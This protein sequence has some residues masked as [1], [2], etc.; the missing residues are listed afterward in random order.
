M[1]RTAL[2]AALIFA[3][4]FSAGC[5]IKPKSLSA[6]AGSEDITYPRTYPDPANDPH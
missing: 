3:L 1:K 6:P 5:G 2:L 4:A